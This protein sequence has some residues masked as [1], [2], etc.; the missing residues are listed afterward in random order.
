MWEVD[1][2]EGLA[3]KNWCF[4]TVVLEK[5]LESLLDSKEI[6]PVHP[7]GNQPWI[8]IGRTNAEA[9]APILW[10]SDAKS[11]PFGKDSDAGKDWSRRR[12][13]RQR[14]RWLD[15]T[16]DWKDMSLNKLQKI[17]KDIGVLQ[18]I[19][20]Q[21]VRHSL[22]TEQRQ[23]VHHCL[24]REKG[25]EKYIL[26]CQHSFEWRKVQEREERWEKEER[27]WVKSFRECSWG[28]HKNIWTNTLL[29]A[30]F[31]MAKT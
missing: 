7:K 1:H 23:A 21:R 2:T 25:V 27:K 29:Q 13:G 14:I 15:G 3:T 12:R 6:K 28:K 26:F 5:I 10:P 16:T 17:V 19:G 30:Y 9:E 8:F 4:R 24:G 31:I 18:S 20:S 11:W 22:V